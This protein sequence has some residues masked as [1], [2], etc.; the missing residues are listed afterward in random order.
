MTGRGHSRAKITLYALTY[1]N[2]TETASIIQPYEEYGLQLVSY[3][4]PPPQPRIYRVE[5]EGRN[6]TVDMTEWAG[7]T[8]YKD[9][10]ITVALR[11]FNGNAHDFIDRVSGRLCRMIFTPDLSDWAYVGRCEDITTEIRYKMTDIT[12]KFTCHP[13]RY[14]VNADDYA[15]SSTG[16][17]Y[18]GHRVLTLQAADSETNTATRYLHQHVLSY[19]TVTVSGVDETSNTAHTLTV[20][21]T[22]YEITANGT[23]ASQPAL[24]P[25]SNSIS[26]TNGGD[27]LTV[28][29]E[30]TFKDQVI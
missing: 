8:F 7:E 4:L 20:N 6:G 13:F 29:A 18:S 11:D 21:G 1:A 30:I 26:L 17:A 27:D 10:T 19:A 15:P 16:Q 14:P 22:D 5:V 3:T 24:K 25:G 23:L 9:R 28:I 2:G 12:L